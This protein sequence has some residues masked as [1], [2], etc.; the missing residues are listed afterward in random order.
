M[1]LHFFTA[2]FSFLWQVC[3]NEEHLRDGKVSH[4][5]VPSL[6]LD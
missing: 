5:G 6:D 2:P 4:W 1:N 3:Y